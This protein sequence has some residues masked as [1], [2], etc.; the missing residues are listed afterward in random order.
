MVRAEAGSKGV[1]MAPDVWKWEEIGPVVLHFLSNGRNIHS[2]VKSMVFISG[3]SVF[4]AVSGGR[5]RWTN[6]NSTCEGGKQ[7]KT[8][9]SGM[10]IQYGYCDSLALLLFL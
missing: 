2:E 4:L 1:L 7:V 9:F 8:S 3:I 6:A 5:C 10:D